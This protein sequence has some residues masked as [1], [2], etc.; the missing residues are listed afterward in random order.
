MKRAELLYAAD[1]NQ[2][3]EW[4]QKNHN[5]KKEV[6][7]VFYKK[8]TGKP[9]IH[10]DDAVEEALCFGWVD[11]IIKRLDDDRCAR[12]FTPRKSKSKWSETNRKRAER[13]IKERKM[14]EAGLRAIAWAKNSGE[15]QKRT[16]PRKEFVIP[17]YIM[18]ALEANKKALDNFNKLANTYRRHFAGWITSAKR[19]KT[20][21]K[22]LVEAI[23]LLEQ[24][25]KLG[26]K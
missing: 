17:K 23:G 21:Q 4:L 8:H 12:K 14:T 19:E 10:Y 6:W 13:M 5:T 22:R 2:W 25:K 26:M 16:S 3:Q 24:N 20:R 7:L 18:E 15:W 9:T 1:R 11:S